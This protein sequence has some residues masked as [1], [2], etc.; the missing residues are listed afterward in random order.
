MLNIVLNK[1]ENT[2]DRVHLVSHFPVFFWPQ[3]HRGQQTFS[4][5][6]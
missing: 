4:V 2:E 6:G 5:K 3:Y 1:Y